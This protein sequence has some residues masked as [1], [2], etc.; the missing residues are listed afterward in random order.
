MGGE[1]VRLWVASVD[2]REDMAASE[3][4]M[5]RCAE[6]YRKLRNTFRFLLGNL[7]GFDP[8]R[9]RVAEADLL[10]L[11]RYMLARTRDLTEKILAWYAAFEFHRIYQAVNEFAIVD[12][13]AFYLDAL[14]D[15]M[16]TFAPTS[17][18]RR[19]AQTVLWQ[20][21]ET[22]VRLVAPILSFTAD[23]VWEHL[24]AVEGRPVSV[25]LALFPKPE[26][27]FSEDPTKLLDEWKQIFAVRDAALR[28]LEEKRQGKI[29]GKGLEA[30]VVVHAKGELL[31]LLQR[32]AAGLKEIF[33]VSSVKVTDEGRVGDHPEGTEFKVIV[34]SDDLF[35]EVLP[36]S[37]HKCARCWNFM[38]EVSNYGIWPNVCTRCHD[39]LTQMGIDPP[40]PEAAP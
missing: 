5:Q 21:T 36:A 38:P 18:A 4:L 37:G 40:Q 39:A 3:N 12:L 28:N 9:H 26:E 7:N 23:E 24:P 22:L 10:P 34:P 29:I 6:L 20:I 30:D 35:F 2:F 8:A 27:V 11:D 31:A 15:R 14:K 25:H 33:N 1:I 32:H 16:Y 17:Q 13:S 19:S